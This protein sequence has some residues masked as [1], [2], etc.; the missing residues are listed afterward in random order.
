MVSD[1][2]SR[3]QKF[4]A[5]IA[6]I[7]VFPPAAI[8]GGF[9]PQLNVLPFWGWLAIAMIG[10]SISVVIV[11]GWPL[12]G[13]IA[14]LM[15][16]LGA[17]LAAYFYGYVRLTLLGSSY[18]FFAEPFVAS[19]VGMIPSFIYLANVPYKARIDTR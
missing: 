12:H 16:G 15:L 17:V 9:L 5:I 8:A 10:G 2:E 13:T 4:G 11:S 14:G 1:G 6:V 18:F 3:G 7:L 19:V